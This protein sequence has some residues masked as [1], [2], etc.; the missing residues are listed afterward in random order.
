V[1]IARSGYQVIGF[2]GPR[3]GWS[4]GGLRPGAHREW[5]RPVGAVLDHFGLEGVTIVGISLGGGLAIRAAAHEP[6]VARVTADD[7]LTDFLACNLRQFPADVPEGL[8]DAVRRQL[9]HL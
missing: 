3:P 9:E 5:H 1:A 4:P 8:P 7:I 6:R 2:D